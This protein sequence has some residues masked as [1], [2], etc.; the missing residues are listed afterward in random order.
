M[1]ILTEKKQNFDKK[2]TFLSNKI[3]LLIIWSSNSTWEYHG[4][5]VEPINEII[6]VNLT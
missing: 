5:L 1:E 4:G 2:Q 3:A 6:S